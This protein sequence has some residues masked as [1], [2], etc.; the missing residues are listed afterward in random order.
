[1]NAIRDLVAP[2]LS[3]TCFIVQRRW[4]CSRDGDIHFGRSLCCKRIN[5]RSE[6]TGKVA[7]IHIATLSCNNVD[8]LKV[9]ERCQFQTN[10][11]EVTSVLG[12]PPLM[13]AIATTISSGAGIPRRCSL[14]M[15]QGCSCY[16]M[17]WLRGL[18]RSFC[19][20]ILQAEIG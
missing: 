10:R 18:T 4:G 3:R 14:A 13:R 2:P 1:M 5:C 20:G 8:N 12:S 6:F 9:P 15:P 7:I 11:S 19:H 17:Q 16:T